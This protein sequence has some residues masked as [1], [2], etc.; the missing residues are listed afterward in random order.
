MNIYYSKKGVD[1]LFYLVVVTRIRIVLTTHYFLRR[2]MNKNDNKVNKIDEFS[3][4]KE[5]VKFSK[6]SRKYILVSIPKIHNDLR[7][8]LQDETHNLVKNILYATY[9]KGNIRMKYLVELLVSISMIDVILV[10]LRSVKEVKEK[11]IDNAISLLHIIK[12]I[13]YGWKCNEE[14]KRDE[15]YI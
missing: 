2:V 10:E 8:H 15:K 14:K 13:V 3:L 12:N 9:N 7:I 1:K 11:K 4:L 5:A 6:Y